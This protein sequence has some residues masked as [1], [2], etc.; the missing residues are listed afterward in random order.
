VIS[1]WII[2]WSVTIG[3]HLKSKAIWQICYVIIL[4]IIYI[5]YNIWYI[6]YQYN[7]WYIY[8]LIFII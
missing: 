2:I 4:Y 8:N 5:I 3:N 7:M 6:Q 1:H